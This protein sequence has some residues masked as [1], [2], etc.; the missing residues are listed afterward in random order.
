MKP[1][2]IGRFEKLYATFLSSAS[3]GFFVINEKGDFLVANDAYALLVG[4]SREELLTM[5]I[6]SLR[7][8]E[9]PEEPERHFENAM[10][11][12]KDRF[13]V[14]HRRKDGTFV[15][16]EVSVSYIK[17]EGD[18]LFF[19]LVRDVADLKKA[20]ALALRAEEFEDVNRELKDAQLAMGDLIDDARRLEEA[21]RKEKEGVEQKV[22]ERTLE[23]RE[24][25]ARLV[26]SIT[27]LPIGFV[28]VDPDGSFV[29]ANPALFRLFGMSGTDKASFRDIASKFV[30]KPGDGQVVFEVERER[31]LR[32]KR[33]VEIGSIPFG[34]KFLHVFLSP[35]VVSREDGEAVIGMVM[36]FEDITEREILAQSEKDF[37]AIASHEMRTPLA[38]IRGNA[39][40]MLENDA[41]A[42]EHLDENKTLL[43][44][45]RRSAM[46]LLVIINEFLDVLALEEKRVQF[47]HD[48]VD[49]GA[50][51]ERCVEELMGIA[52][53]KKLV[54][55][56]EKPALPVPFVAADKDRLWQV[57]YN[58]VTN[59]L[60]YTNTG[61]VTVR[62]EVQGDSLAIIVQDTG[63]GMTAEQQRSLF[64]KFSTVSGSFM[65][66]RE[67]GSGLG[68]YITRMLMESMSG[69][70]E[71]EKSAPGTGSV[72]VVKVPLAH[73]N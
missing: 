49:I 46:R 39:E 42:P 26:A 15:D 2:D 23:L 31:V 60:H 68:L 19:E 58:L 64:K 55:S 11:D 54:L 37:I 20:E 29:I 10:R 57:V 48:T 51:I 22:Q 33:S 9:R 52:T 3:D 16:L 13:D 32:E 7:A 72:F 25:R 43:D 59:A 61:S 50:I 63:I 70:V 5:N 12:G 67:Y 47:K 14:R 21:L 4:Y 40:L 17:E 18:G 34:N 53:E 56:F 65:H 69:S 8:N 6:A 27:N 45:T 28:I 44:G 41:L 38:I 30:S 66:S 62:V 36:L 1:E 24:E 35:V 71:L 73:S